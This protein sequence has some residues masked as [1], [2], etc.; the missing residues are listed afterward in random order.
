MNQAIKAQWV[1]AL[2]SGRYQQG[3][4]VLR[5]LSDNY[6]CLGVLCDLIAPSDWHEADRGQFAHH[7]GGAF[8]PGQDILDRLGL[9]RDGNLGAVRLSEMNDSGSNFYS[10]ADFIESNL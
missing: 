7:H 6:C 10:I 1:E 4:N 2:R 9:E 3:K 5:S 8:M